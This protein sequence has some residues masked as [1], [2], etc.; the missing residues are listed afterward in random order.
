MPPIATDR[1]APL[2]RRRW[3][4]V[5]GLAAGVIALLALT[6]TAFGPGPATSTTGGQATPASL[7][8]ATLAG[9]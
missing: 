5:A 3:P 6:Y 4:L 1:S 8:A 7:T 2:L 9:Q